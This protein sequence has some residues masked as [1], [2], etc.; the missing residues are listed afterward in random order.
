MEALQAKL[1]EALVSHWPLLVAL[2]VVSRWV[3]PWGLKQTLQNGGGLIIRGIVKEENALQ[4]AASAAT[5][6]RIVD[7]SIRRHE[8]VEERRETA[9]GEKVDKLTE[10]VAKLEVRRELEAVH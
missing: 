9:L 10:R 8:L 3:F 6:Q 4:S 1:V 5:T 7:D 2:A